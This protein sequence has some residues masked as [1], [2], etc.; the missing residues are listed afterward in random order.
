MRRHLFSTIGRRPTAEDSSGAELRQ[1][2]LETA[3]RHWPEIP[4]PVARR[5][6]WLVDVESDQVFR[7]KPGMVFA[8]GSSTAEVKGVDAFYVDRAGDVVPLERL[9]SPATWSDWVEQRARHDV[10]KARS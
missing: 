5:R 2:R 9:R 1:A 8:R 4:E 3:R 10:E 7:A 6:D